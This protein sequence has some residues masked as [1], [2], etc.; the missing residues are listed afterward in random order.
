MPWLDSPSVAD[1]REKAQLL[2]I[3]AQVTYETGEIIEGVYDSWFPKSQI[4][5]KDGHLRIPDWL[6]D[7]KEVELKEKIEKVD[8]RKVKSVFLLEVEMP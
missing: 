5:W 1:D 3:E 8:K 2:L 4:E 6:R 7:K